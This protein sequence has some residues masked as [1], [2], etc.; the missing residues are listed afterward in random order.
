M[1]ANAS[2]SNA[3]IAMFQIRAD[4]FINSDPLGKT[5]ARIMHGGLADVAQAVEIA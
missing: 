4:F 1:K 5:L 3:A 2:A